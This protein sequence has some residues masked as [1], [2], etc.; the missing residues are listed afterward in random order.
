M[1]N[2]SSLT[3]RD[4]PGVHSLWAANSIVTTRYGDFDLEIACPKDEIPGRSALVRAGSLV[5]FARARTEFIVDLAYAHFR[6]A[7]RTWGEDVFRIMELPVASY[8]RLNVLHEARTRKLS[9]VCDAEQ[10]VVIWSGVSLGIRYD[11]EH[12]LGMD[13]D[14]SEIVSI[15]GSRFRLVGDELRFEE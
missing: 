7:V 4:W 2:L 10:G 3:L 11:E 13:F 14:G 15:D 1:V 9:V 8:T 12:G 6:W 5:E